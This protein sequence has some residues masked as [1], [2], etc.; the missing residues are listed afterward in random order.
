MPANE[1]RFLELRDC[2][3]R[4]ARIFLEVSERHYPERLAMFLC[5]NAPPLFSG[6]WRIVE[7]IVDPDTRR[8]IKFVS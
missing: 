7:P 5:I 6:L 4:L 2:D 1:S 3:P 8:K